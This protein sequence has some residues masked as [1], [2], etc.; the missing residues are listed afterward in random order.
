MTLTWEAGK[1]Q[2]WQLL[3]DQN[4]VGMWPNASI[5]MRVQSRSRSSTIQIPGYATIRYAPAVK[6]FW[7][8]NWTKVKEKTIPLTSNH[9][10]A[11]TVIGVI[12]GAIVSRKCNLPT[13][14]L[15]VSTLYCDFG[16]S[17]WTKSWCVKQTH[18]KLISQNSTYKKLK[19]CRDWKNTL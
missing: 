8:R 10:W 7:L 12:T 1:K 4:G 19:S 2:R 6:I 14:I 17:A 15:Q 13:N 5:W 16:T 3:T 9:V 18:N 11:G